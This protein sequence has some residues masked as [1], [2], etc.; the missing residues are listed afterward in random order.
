[1]GAARR[2]AVR[3]GLVMA[4]VVV[5]VAALAGCSSSGPAKDSR[6]TPT[7]SA[8][9]SGPDLSTSSLWLSFEQESIDF[10]GT[11]TYP[12]ALDG[13]FDARVMVSNGGS[14]EVV[15]GAGSARAV[16]FPEK[17]T[18]R[19]GCPRAL[20]EV[21]SDPALDPGDAEFEYG[22]SVWLA[23]DQTTTGSN[24]VQKGR[25]GSAGGQWKLQVDSLAGEP[26][27]VLRSGDDQLIARSSVSIADSAWHD[28]VCRRD[29]EGLTIRVDD[30]VDRV[31]GRT[32]SVSNQWPVRVGSPGVGD[33]DDHFHGRVDDVFL[34]IDPPA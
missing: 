3:C 21:A 18:A 4:P 17:C 10:D 24:I 7:P 8:S 2:T 9:P 1:M 23:P 30:T 33:D 16:A 6:L 28:V 22:A 19:K 11:T 12:D 26:S 31:D 15:P 25:F 20:L 27:C 5:L 14:V 29:R 32:G 13:P 34:R